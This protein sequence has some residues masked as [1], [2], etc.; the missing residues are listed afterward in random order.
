MNLDRVF[1]FI[2]ENKEVMTWQEI[3]DSL[4]KEFGKKYTESAYRK[5]YQAFIKGVEFANKLGSMDK[6]L[7]IVAS[8]R[9]KLKTEKAIVSRERY[10]TNQTI[11]KIATYN[12]FSK[13]VIGN[14]QKGYPSIT[15]IKVEDK[16]DKFYLV[17]IADLH[18]KGYENLDMI[19]SEMLSNILH[20]QKELGFKEIIVAEM[21]DTVEGA[22]LRTSQ[23]LAIKKGLIDQT[24]DVAR[25]YSEFLTELSKSMR[26]RF[27]CVE[28]SNHTQL[29]NLGT[30]RNELPA[31]DTMKVLSEFVKARCEQNPNIDIISAPEVDM[32]YKGFGFTFVHGHKK[33]NNYMDVYSA[34]KGVQLDYMFSAH[35]HHSRIETISRADG[36]NRELIECPSACLEE[37]DYEKNKILS[38]MP[39]ILFNCFSTVK[40]RV[41]SEE[42]F[43][44]KSLKMINGKNKRKVK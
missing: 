39:S 8:A 7:D 29:R 18:Y 9:V 16:S 19:F 21:G 26:V 15:P 14:I 22:T 11:N 33:I 41:Y 36:Y 20:K 38:S 44:D 23:L 40:G 32:N 31:E 30:Q 25:Y 24:L 17:N 3:A 1:E 35:Y 5:P 6:Q 4:N 27:I 42:L 28:E 10:I 37:S 34:R 2:E 13:E 43:L 12:L